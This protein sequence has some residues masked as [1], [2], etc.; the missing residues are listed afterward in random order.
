MRDQLH[1]FASRGTGDAADAVN[2]GVATDSDRESDVGTAE[3]SAS[4]RVS[5]GAPAA[6]IRAT[7]RGDR[8]YRMKPKR[9]S[10]HTTRAERRTI[11]KS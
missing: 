1:E 11:Q 3:G 5:L 2:D 8:G 10:G 6:S 7:S 4:G 9:R